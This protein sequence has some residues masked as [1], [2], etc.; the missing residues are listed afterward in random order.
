MFCT[1]AIF[2]LRS[3]KSVQGVFASSNIANVKGVTEMV[4]KISLI[5]LC[6]ALFILQGCNDDSDPDVTPPT[7]TLSPAATTYNL[8]VGD[9]VPNI[10]ATAVDDVDG[11]I[12]S[13][14][15]VTGDTVDNQSEGTYTVIYNV[16]DT[17]GNNAQAVSVTFI[18]V[19]PPDTDAPIISISPS[20]L[21]YDLEIGADIPTISI[22]AFDERDGDLSDQIEVS[23]DTVNNQAVGTYAV[24]YNVSDS[25]GNEAQE[26]VIQFHVDYPK[27]PEDAF[28]LFVNGEAVT[29][30]VLSVTE[31]ELV[32]FSIQVA[33]S[34]SLS[35]VRLVSPENFPINFASIPEGW[36]TWRG[37]NIDLLALDAKSS[38]DVIA[39]SNDV[40]YAQLPH[41]DETVTQTLRL[42]F[43]TAQSAGVYEVLYVHDFQIEVSDAGVLPESGFLR[44][45]FSFV[46][47][48]AVLAYDLNS[49]YAT[50]T[51]T[52]D[53]LF[54]VSLMPDGTAQSFVKTVDGRYSDSMSTTA[55]D[56]T[57][58]D[59]LVIE[60]GFTLDA[61][62]GQVIIPQLQ[63]SDEL[64]VD[65]S[66][67]SALVK[68]IPANTCNYFNGF[69]IT[70]DGIVDE[71]GTLISPMEGLCHIASRENASNLYVLDQEAM[72][73]KTIQIKSDATIE[74]IDFFTLS[75]LPTNDYEVV[76]F[77]ESGL[78]VKEQGNANAF[79]AFLLSEDPENGPLF[80][81]HIV[82]S[83]TEISDILVTRNAFGTQLLVA[84]PQNTFVTLYHSLESD[85][86]VKEKIAFD[87]PI[88]WMNLSSS[89]ADWQTLNFVVFG[90]R[91]ANG[92]Y[93]KHDFLI[94]SYD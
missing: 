59:N 40:L 77:N 31:S 18:Y 50:A 13:D 93:L 34:T 80:D 68:P 60:K 88:E 26:V 32:A 79:T 16:Q 71:N 72:E 83:E 90:G 51:P 47:T 23:G 21:T 85:T 37:S 81:R 55:L 38:L 30:D 7:I 46:E 94:N 70:P 66:V 76:L 4:R 20:N 78:V 5:L 12:S 3:V 9:V 25:A 33:G 69:I 53:E 86:P 2:T 52:Y 10:T 62:K 67:Q 43:L 22:T 63:T 28:E 11:D 73:I 58:I 49:P 75:N 48:G 57:A 84:N 61:S 74:V 24:R 91:N 45:D 87:T 17:A 42:E 36:N 82:L 65:S 8:T 89:P 44:S 15:V 19:L 6:G 92:I 54:G 39:F 41:V 64:G 56:G 29:N 35:S 27:A 1:A 14:I